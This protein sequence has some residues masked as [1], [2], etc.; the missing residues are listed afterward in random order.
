MPG[1]RTEKWRN[2]QTKRKAGHEVPWNNSM[3]WG[4][5]VPKLI[6]GMTTKKAT[7]SWPNYTKNVSTAKVWPSRSK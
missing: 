2:G 5:L 6:S 3:P 7:K 4:V 1:T